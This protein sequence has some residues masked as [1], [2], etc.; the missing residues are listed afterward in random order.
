MKKIIIS[1][2]IYCLFFIIHETSAYPT[3][4]IIYDT[5]SQ[6]FI[7]TDAVGTETDLNINPSLQPII[8]RTC[9][10]TGYSFGIDCAVIDPTDQL[11]ITLFFGS[12]CVKATCHIC[13]TAGVYSTFYGDLPPSGTN[14]CIEFCITD[15]VP[16]TA[17]SVITGDPHFVGFHGQKFD[18]QGNHNTIYNIYSD[19]FISINAHFHA[20]GPHQNIMTIVGILFSTHSLVLHVNATLNMSLNIIWDNLLTTISTNQ[21]ITLTECV[22]V[23]WKNE[24]FILHTPMHVITI[25]FAKAGSLGYFNIFIAQTQPQLPSE[26]GGIVGQTVY[27]NFTILENNFVE[28]SILSYNSVKNQFKKINLCNITLIADTQTKYAIVGHGKE[29]RV[30]IK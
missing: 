16:T 10:S 17:Q 13:S 15:D 11:Q 5:A 19:P 29:A 21:T 26:E 22:S 28:E 25:K 23:V 27:N 12:N 24:A 3:C 2:L 9:G 1:I 7:L 20:Y 18:F 8:S 30:N 6:Q 4:T 14:L